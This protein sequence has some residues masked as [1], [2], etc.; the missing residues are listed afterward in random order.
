MSSCNPAILLATTLF[1]TVLAAAVNAADLSVGPNGCMQRSQKR[2]NLHTA[3]LQ[4][5]AVIGKGQ[6]GYLAVWSS[7]R[8]QAGRQGVY[9]RQLNH[10]GAAGG[11]EIRLG[12]SGGTHQTSPAVAATPGGWLVAWQSHGQDG[13][14]GGIVAAAVSAA[15]V[16][17]VETVVNERTAGEQTSAAI[18]TLADGRGL[19]VWTHAAA[20]AECAPP[21]VRARWI[22]ADGA[23]L[24]PAFTIDGP[25]T[26]A[27][28]PAL[29]ATPSGDIVIVVATVGAANRPA[30]IG[31]GRVQPGEAVVTDAARLTGEPAFQPAIVAAT[32]GVVVGWHQHKGDGTSIMAAAVETEKLETSRVVAVAG[33]SASARSG[34]ALAAGHLEDRQAREQIVAFWNEG[35]PGHSR[36]QASAGVVGRELLL[37]GTRLSLGGSIRIGGHASVALGLNSSA[38]RVASGRASGNCAG[39]GAGGL[40]LIGTGDDGSG[41]VDAVVVT[42]L[43]TTGWTPIGSGSSAQASKAAAHETSGRAQPH[44]PPVHAAVVEPVVERTPIESSRGI[45]F[46]GIVNTGWN[47]PDPEIAVGPGHV[48][49]I[50]NGSISFFTRDGTLE[51]ETTISGGGG[52]WGSIGATTVVFDPEVV[53]D[54]VSERFFAMAVEDAGSSSFILLAVSDDADPNGVWYRYRYDTTGQAGGLLD[55]PNMA[56]GS[57][58]VFISG[59]AL[60]ITPEYVVYVFN[61]ASLLAGNPPGFV[62]ELTLPSGPKS[63]GVPPIVEAGTL[64]LMEHREDQTGSNTIRVVALTNPFFEPTFHSQT[65]TVPFYDRPEQPPQQGTTFRPAVFDARFWSVALAGDS[66]WGAHHAG[67]DRILARWYEV[68][69]NGW[70]GSGEIPTL[71]QSGVIDPGPGVRTF[72]PGIAVDEHGNTTVAFARSSFSEFI[73]LNSVSRY[74]SDPPGTMGEPVQVRVSTG[75]SSTSRW[76][77]YTGIDIDPVD[78]KT[79]W[80]HGEYTTAGGWR[81][82]IQS[83]TPVF[84]PADINCDGTVGRGDLA[85]L[86]ASWGACNGAGDCV[87]DLNADGAVDVY[88]LLLLLTR[89]S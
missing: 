43:T 50:T 87:A 74:A 19:V 68:A 55:S 30:G 64:Y 5:Q 32:G 13:D 60:G 24:S 23:I 53:Y 26:G 85:V 21:S 83:R 76:G 49:A 78:G 4:H 33:R 15:G 67:S 45:G 88:D 18:A 86:L 6:E 37:S 62:S 66:L 35:A 46:L 12:V 48:V 17:G 20:E 80:V 16:P 61:K 69:L 36:A 31:I 11:P 73:S 82:W 58:A 2:V 1:V 77:D 65:L 27:C 70:P 63:L 44:Q 29:V 56:I 8:Q 9:A 75:P 42:R 28:S 81:T 3:G 57:S 39:S 47:P 7:R 34:L 25:W 52:F 72:F 51:F 41:D 79:T 22:T 14:R 89:W 38:G 84:D 71:R 40:L 59:D 54:C 10:L